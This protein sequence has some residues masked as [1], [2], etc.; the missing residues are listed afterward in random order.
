MQNRPGSAAA[1]DEEQGPAYGA[2]SST[3]KTSMFIHGRRKRLNG[4]AICQ[5]IFA[6]WA[7]YCAAS[8][9]C[10]FVRNHHP[11]EAV[12]ILAAL[13]AIVVIVGVYAL[14]SM[15]DRDRAPNW[16]IFLFLAVTAAW[17]LGVWWGC[18]TFDLY[19]TRY[20]DFLGLQK[21]VDVDVRK[22]QSAQLMDAASVAFV[23]GTVLDQ[24]RAMGFREKEQFCVVPIVVPGTPVQSYDFW[25]VGKN[26]CAENATD[27][28]FHCGEW[29]NPGAHSG[30]RLME[31][32]ERPFYRLAV[33]QAEAKFS[34]R[35]ARPIFF[36]WME[37]PMRGGQY[38]LNDGY[39]KASRPVMGISTYKEKCLETYFIGVLCHLLLSVFFVAVAS[40]AFSNSRSF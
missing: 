12:A 9:T 23:P 40:V 14:R 20:N 38:G 7:L 3:M 25:A 5:C 18:R 27:V 28:W 24:A 10:V 13:L 30:L 11:V 22:H 2:T 19:W 32:D 17:C 4:A 31:D 16:Y 29:N 21:Y 37:D 36:H 39:F 15:F 34:I 35:S 8:A 6:P 26:C 33:Q 1:E